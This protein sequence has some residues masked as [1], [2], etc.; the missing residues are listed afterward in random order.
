VVPAVVLGAKCQGVLEIVF[1]VPGNF[2]ASLENPEKAPRVAGLPD[3]NLR[4]KNSTVR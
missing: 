4:E 1:P 3:I 2:V